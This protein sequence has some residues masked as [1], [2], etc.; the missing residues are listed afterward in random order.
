M[1]KR[2][3]SGSSCQTISKLLL[4]GIVALI[5]LQLVI[6]NTQLIIANIKETQVKLDQKVAQIQSTYSSEIA[7]L[8]QKDTA[9][10]LPR[11]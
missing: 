8:E 11:N 7:N 1:K 4:I 2:R 10:E 5:I 6:Y 9:G 3:I